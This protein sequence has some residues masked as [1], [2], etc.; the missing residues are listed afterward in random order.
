MAKIIEINPLILPSDYQEL[1]RPLINQRNEEKGPLEALELAQFDSRTIFYD[2]FFNLDGSRLFAIGP[3]FL[4]LDKYIKILQLTVNGE[5][6]EFQLITLP[7]GLIQLTAKLT[8]PVKDKNTINISFENFHWSREI[9]FFRT[10]GSTPLAL[11]TLQRDNRIQWILDWIKYY[12]NALNVKRFIIYDNLSKY[13]AQ[14]TEILPDNVLVVPWNSPF[15]PTE[16]HPNKFLHVGQLNH[17]RLRFEEIDTFL[18]FDIDELLVI[19]DERVK[20]LISKSPTV[21][22][23]GYRV[24]YISIDKENYSYSDFTR[25]TSIPQNGS[26]KY[27]FSRAAISGNKMHA[28][29]INKLAARLFRSLF[30]KDVP[31]DQAYFL[32]YNPIN[33]DWKAKTSR[34]GRTSCLKPAEDLNNLVPDYSVKDILDKI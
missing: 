9:S 4:N 21:S 20:T 27:S 15:G 26:P 11:T 34:P 16:S 23:T 6:I 13:Q 1:R 2:V 5:T 12:E 32:H 29:S 14:L 30:F 24:P 3:P 31:V 18:N 8:S 22:F 19:K 7:K 10:K 33:T 28:V 17:S 25:R